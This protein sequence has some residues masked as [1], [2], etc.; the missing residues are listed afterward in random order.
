MSTLLSATTMYGTSTW[1]ASR[2]CS[3]LCGS[4]V[5]RRATRIARPS[6]APVDHVLD[7]VGVPGQSTARSGRFAVSF[8]YFDVRGVDCDGHAALLRALSISA[9]L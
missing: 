7:V 2:M 1:R 9:E 8:H 4:G 3:T 6:A 5:G